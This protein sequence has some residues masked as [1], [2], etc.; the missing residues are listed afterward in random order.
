MK[1]WFWLF[2]FQ[3]TGKKCHGIDYSLLWCALIG[4]I[5]KYQFCLYKLQEH[6]LQLHFMVV[7][8]FSGLIFHSFFSLISLRSHIS[9]IFFFDVISHI[10]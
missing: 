8:F 3:G 9:L 5:H 7:I 10:K 4:H 1:P 2:F 6:F